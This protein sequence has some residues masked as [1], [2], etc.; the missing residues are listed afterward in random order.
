MCISV[1]VFVCVS[2]AQIILCE[3]A[4]VSVLAVLL[5]SKKQVWSKE[6]K[7]PLSS[8]HKPMGLHRGFLYMGVLKALESPSEMV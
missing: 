7:V 3:C 2:L 1:Y 8:V 6:E 5:S 4:S